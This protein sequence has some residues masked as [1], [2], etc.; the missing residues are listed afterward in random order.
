MILSQH[1][2]KLG[3]QFENMKK[4]KPFSFAFA[5]NSVSTQHSENRRQLRNIHIESKLSIIFITLMQHHQKQ[6]KP[7]NQ[8]KRKTFFK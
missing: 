5:V 6:G 4:K 2:T 8:H 1:T 3:E 7:T